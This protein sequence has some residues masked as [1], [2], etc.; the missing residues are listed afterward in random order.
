MMPIGLLF[1]VGRYQMTRWPCLVEVFVNIKIA[2]A[3]II[4]RTVEELPADLQASIPIRYLRVYCLA[5]QCT[6]CLCD[7]Q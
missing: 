2:V 6:G 4:E 3:E 1:S 5:T 7:N